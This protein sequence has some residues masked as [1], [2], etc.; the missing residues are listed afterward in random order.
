MKGRYSGRHMTVYG[1]ILPRAAGI[2]RSA[3]KTADLSEQAKQR[4][5]VLDWH[6]AHGKNQSLTSRRFGLH[7]ETLRIWLMRLAQS[8]PVGLNDHSR[9][10]H[11]FRQA[12]VRRTLAAEVVRLRQ[13]YPTYSKYK[14]H[15]LLG[16]KGSPSTIARIL[17]QKNLIDRRISRKRY[18]AAIKPKRRYP[19]GM[20]IHQAGQLIQMDTKH[21][22]LPD[23]HKLYQFT[24][25]DVLTKQRVLS[26]Y[27]SESSRNGAAFLDECLERFPAGVGAL[28]TDNGAPFQK[29]LE[30]HCQEL[31][32][33][34]YFIEPRSPK[35]NSYV[36]ASHGADERE[37][38]QCG[39][40]ASDISLM[41]RFV[42]E[43]ERV[44]N[45]IRPHQALGY[46][47][48]DQYYAENKDRRVGT[49]QTVILQ[50]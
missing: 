39:K 38:Y 45:T 18:R 44:W 14:L 27:S 46:R 30:R 17:K 40:I 42:A 35:Q 2:A 25:I 6:H 29:E 37:F 19:R 50:T 31:N 28:Q 5:K 23:G 15:V 47:T 8:G 10:P 49:Q 11:R 41:R 36:E 9:R 4:L 33:P 32:I 48:P 13:Q 22:C 3:Q 43:R 1:S 21:I 16:R 12:P 26:V 24:A 7:R 34:H 20:S